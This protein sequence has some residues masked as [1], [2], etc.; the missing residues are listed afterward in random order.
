[1]KVTVQFGRTGIVVPC[2]DGTLTVQQLIHQAVQRYC[3]NTAKDAGYS[4]KIHHLEYMDG[5]ILDPDDILIDVVEDKDKLVAVYEEQEMHRADEVA[6][7]S[8]ADRQSPDTFESE[9]AAQLA[10]FQPITGEIEVTPSA[11]K[12]GT[13]L[14]VRRSSDPALVPPALFQPGASHSDESPNRN[15]IVKPVIAG[16]NWAPTDDVR[17]DHSGL[18]DNHSKCTYSDLTKKVEFSGDGGPLGI[19]VVPFNSTLSGRFLGLCIRGIEENSRSKRER[20]LQEN[21]CIVKINDSDLTDRTFV[22]AQE[23][24]RNAMQLPA[25]QLQIVPGYNRDRYERSAIGSLSSYNHEDD[26]KTKFPPPLRPKPTSKPTDLTYSSSSEN[27]SPLILMQ[28]SSPKQLRSNSHSVLPKKTS[29]PTSFGGLGT[30]KQGKKIKIDLKKGTEGLGFTVVTRESSVHGPGPILVKNILQRGAAVKDGRLQSGD[31][32]LEVNG[33]DITGKAQEELVAMLRST[34]QGETVALVIARQ[35]DVFVPRELKGEQNC[36]LP[37]DDKKEYLT[38]E[39]PLNDSGSAGLGISLKGNK[40]KDTGADLGIFIKAI[41]HGGAAFKDGRLRMNDQLIAVNGEHLLEKSNHEALETLR[42]SMSM[43]GN[44]R[45]MIQVMVARRMEKHQEDRLEVGGVQIHNT[46]SSNGTSQWHTQ[47]PGFRERVTIVNDDG[48][49]EIPPPDPPHPEEEEAM[50]VYKMWSFREDKSSDL[51]S[52]SQ[53]L[54]Q[55]PM[56][57]P[58]ESQASNTVKRQSPG[59][60]SSSKSMDLVADES[61]V[62]SLA[63]YQ[64]DSIGNDVGPM[65]GLKKSSSL[66]SLQTAVAEVR[67]N[68]LPFHRPRPHMVRGRGCNESFRAAIDKSYDGPEIPD[69]DSEESSQSGHETPGSESTLQ[70]NAELEDVENSDSKA[71]KEKKKKEKKEK[72]KIKGKDKDKE[73]KKE[74]ESQEKKA[75]KKGFGA[76]L[77]FGKK[78]EEKG[79]EQKSKQKSDGLNEEELER[80]K[81]E[82]DRIEAKH[83]ELRERQ[84]K[85]R[86]DQLPSTGPSVPDIEDDD[87]DPNYAKVNHFREPPPTAS[88]FKAPSPQL[89]SIN[90]PRDFT[91]EQENLDG[92]YAKI[93]KQQTPTPDSARPA[94]LDRI[95]Q[96]RKEYHQARR[97]G[98]IPSYEELEGRRWPNDYEPPWIQA[99]VKGPNGR[100]QFEELEHQYTTLPRHLPGEPDEYHLRGPYGD[101]EPPRYLGAQHHVAGYP[102]RGSYPR[103]AADGRLDPRIP[104]YLNSARL[105]EAAYNLP[106]QYKGPHRHD[107]PPSP[108][109]TFKMPR[110]HD[111]GKMAYRESSPDRYRY[112]YQDGR[113]QDPRQK[114]GMTAAV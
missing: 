18:M 31:R 67:K 108:T 64:Y 20:L 16:A 94:N 79:K 98:A 15:L 53:M 44:I 6:N 41:L 22:Q 56:A 95:H 37:G 30:K 35:D 65:L 112:P 81:E 33:I 27:S 100:S 13:P 47:S 68:E 110:H 99:P 62:G 114:N 49:A 42:R 24:F 45:G 75:K 63:M 43:E 96:L 51:N 38:F 21:E 88:V 69:D 55:R 82:R 17:T 105:R 74:N 12:G 89:H 77:R 34:K 39:I 10:A 106:N 76:M 85:E 113:H 40:S 1:M 92:L 7:G 59:K 107:V 9:L 52:A 104:D 86:Y 84:A 93:N 87:M 8:L 48:E 32:I 83:Q 90:P 28:I 103:N 4:I 11:L 2:G 26:S 19:H 78:K 102:H 5:G 29:S 23:V 54:Q 97:E 91:A 61:N 70:G 57:G 66:E 46:R 60:I 73:K 111:H 58:A 36:N 14:M 71:K 109:Q 80:M 72:V 50:G 3:K 25:V 101:R